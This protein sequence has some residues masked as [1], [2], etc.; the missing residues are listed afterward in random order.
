MPVTETRDSGVEILDV[1]PADLE[2]GVEG[3]VFRTDDDV[4]ITV[5]ETVQGR[6]ITTTAD[7][8]VAASVDT[9]MEIDQLTAQMQGLSPEDDEIEEQEDGTLLRN[10]D[11][12]SVFIG[13][14]EGEIGYGLLTVEGGEIEDAIEDFEDQYL[15]DK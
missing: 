6:S 5:G 8:F 14:D 9:E 3:S 2:E 11:E 1:D 7:H 12:S 10:I 4:E 15:S 13:S